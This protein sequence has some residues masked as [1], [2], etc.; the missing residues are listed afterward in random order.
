MAPVCTL[1][2]IIKLG[3]IEIRDLKSFE[4]NLKQT[5]S[6]DKIIS[7]RRNN[8]EIRCLLLGVPERESKTLPILRL[9]KIPFSNEKYFQL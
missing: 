5:K 4:K 8:N 3:E 9:I 1:C 7:S 2:F 6:Y